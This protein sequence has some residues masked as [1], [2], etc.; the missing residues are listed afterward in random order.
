[1]TKHLRM[2][3][4]VASMLFAGMLNAQLQVSIPYQM[5][6]EETDS[7]EW[8]N[9]HINTGANAPACNDQWMV[10]TDQKS[11]GY[12]SLFISSN[13]ISAH[14]GMGPNIQFAYRDFLLPQGNYT[15]AFDWKNTGDNK[16]VLYVG[17]GPATNLACDAIN[18]TG[19]L[20]ASYVTWCQQWVAPGTAPEHYGQRYWQNSRLEGVNSNGS[21]VMR[22][23]FAWCSSNTDTTIINPIGACIDNVQI[24]SSSCAPP[25]SIVVEPSCDSTKVTWSGTSDS[26][27]LGYRRVGENKWHNRTGLVASQ[28]GTTGSLY[29]ENLSEGMYD[30]RVRG[31]CGTDT[32][33]YTYASSIVL[34]CAEQHCINY[35]NLRDTTGTV[36]CRTGEMNY[37]GTVDVTKTRIGVVDYGPDDMGSRHTVNWD[38]DAYD[39]NTNNKLPKIPTGELASVRLGN[40][41]SGSEWESV[42]YDYL[43]DS[44]YS[45]LLL[46]YAVVLEDPNHD[47]V[48]QPRFTLSI[49]DQNGNEVDASCGSADFRAGANVGNK[50]SGW[51]QEVIPD[52]YY[53]GSSTTVVT[54]KEWTTYGIDLSP[55]IGQSLKIVVTTYDCTLGG[56]FGYGYFCLGCV[57]AKIE[58]ISCGDDSKMTAQA[59]DGFAYQWASIHDLNTVVSTART[60]EVDASDTTTYRCRLTYLDQADCY[61][62]LYSSVLPRFPI[63]QF[64]Y[65]YQPSNCENRYVFSNQSHIMVKY[66]GDTSGTHHYDE[67]CD[68]YEWVINGE[69]FSDVDPIYIFP[70]EGG[71]F[72]VTLFASISN[73]KCSD[74]TTFMLNVPK[75]G[76]VEIHVADSI[77]YGSRYVFG[78]QTLTT[79]GIY[80][81][82]FQSRAGCDSVCT[83]HLTVLSQSLTNLTD[84]FICAE[85]AYVVDGDKYPF[86]DSRQWV[87][88]LQNH[89]GCDSTV[90]QNVTLLDTIKP[91]VDVKPI[92]E[93]GDLG[94]FY[95]GGSGYS[96]YTVNGVIHTEDSITDLSPDTYLIIFYNEHGCDKAFTYN[97]NPGCIGGFVYQ[98]W[99]DVLSVKNPEYAGGRSY[100]KY[101]WMKNGMDIPG[102]TKSYYAAAQ[103]PDVEPNGHLDMNA[104]YEVALAVDSSATTEWQISCPYHPIDVFSAL[105]DIDESVL[106]E[107]TYLRCGETIWLLTAD[108]ARVAC[109]SPSGMQVFVKEVS[110][111]RSTIEA[112]SAPGM[113]VVTVYTRS[114]KKSYKI[115]VV[116]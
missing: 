3:S 79:E 57:K 113:Y 51:H 73:G 71:S 116:D 69:R 72:P 35:V 9:W 56:H 6:F 39:P 31:I 60:L 26:Y 34:F 114:G 33:V 74:D 5:S 84:T 28:G 96:Y 109:Y 29:L 67:P 86:P 61:F 19:T 4:M 105:D 44:V 70:E 80:S 45:I 103:F 8:T 95:F 13:G 88:H 49:K 42:T 46:K 23:F 99:N 41:N 90:V 104:V 63:A 101:Q 110:A 93:D 48:E 66:E 55:Y 81:Q 50:G 115:C 15:V 36:V 53:G 85:T 12:R 2:I 89:H 97:L 11:D 21:R 83:L 10:G 18:T 94:A 112:P 16:A 25:S 47:Y 77:C 37:G 43:V 58:G 22:L 106:L 65:T 59:P 27:Q 7:A 82:Q 17:C 38:I 108:K 1:M 62:D 100:K 52:P 76:N 32:S 54:W 98:R 20:P 107:P 92:I 68:E 64:A 102:A 24:C 91:T 30:F 40:W 14:Y 75:I 78:D 111:G 87:R